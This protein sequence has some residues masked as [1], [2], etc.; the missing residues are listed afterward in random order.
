[1]KRIKMFS[2][3]VLSLVLYRQFERL[4]LLSEISV[5]PLLDEVTHCMTFEET[6]ELLQTTLTLWMK[7]ALETGC[8]EDSKKD[9]QKAIDYI[10]GR[11][12]HDLGIDEV[13]EFIGL[14]CSHFCVVFK[15]ETGFTFLEYLTKIPH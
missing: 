8:P 14:S 1:M 15:Q 10:S 4:N 13:A 6:A 12:H 7:N 2:L 11:Y 3:I 5:E 9:V